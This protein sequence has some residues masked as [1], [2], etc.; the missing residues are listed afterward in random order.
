MPILWADVAFELVVGMTAL[1][2]TMMHSGWLGIA[3]AWLYGIAAVFGA[4]SLAI[5]RTPHV[6]VVT[7]LGWAIA[8]GA[9]SRPE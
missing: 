8:S 5:V 4:V 6:P 2:L 9:S 1:A 7:L 3:H